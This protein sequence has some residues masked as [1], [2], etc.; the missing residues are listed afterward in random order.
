[1]ATILLVSIKKAHQN[2]IS[3]ADCEILLRFEEILG[4]NQDLSFLVNTVSCLLQ[5][6]I[7]DYVLLASIDVERSFSKLKHF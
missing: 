5:D 7:F 4:R 2:N 6:R 1:M 3:L